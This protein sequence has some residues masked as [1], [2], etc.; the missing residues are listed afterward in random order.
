MTWA[1]SK[2]EL[3]RLNIHASE[4]AWVGSK[5]DAVIDNNG[6]VDQLHNTIKNLVLDQPAA[7][8]ASADVLLVDN[9]SIQFSN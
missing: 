4:T 6:T 5:F 1:L 2:A 8:A 9:L 3:V 7:M